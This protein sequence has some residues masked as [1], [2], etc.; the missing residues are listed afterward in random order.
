MVGATRVTNPIV[1]VWRGAPESLDDRSTF[2]ESTK[3]LLLPTQHL[4]STAGDLVMY[5]PVW[6]V[7]GGPTGPQSIIS[8]RAR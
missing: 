7:D 3:S 5:K 4:S 2:V 8:T 1:C 6:A